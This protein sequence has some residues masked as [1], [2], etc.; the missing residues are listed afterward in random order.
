MEDLNSFCVITQQVKADASIPEDQRAK[1][2][3]GRLIAS[4]L[5]PDFLV[6]LRS[7]SSESSGENRYRALK[8]AAAERG[9]SR[10]ACPALMD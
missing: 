3:V 1:E 2:I 8:R 7:L 5:G 6:L 4:K 9:A 10:W